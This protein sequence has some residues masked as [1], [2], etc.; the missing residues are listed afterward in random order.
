ML[1]SLMLC[2]TAGCF[3]D[4]QVLAPQQDTVVRAIHPVVSSIQAPPGSQIAIG[5]EVDPEAGLTLGS[6]LG[7]LTFD[8]SKLR[9]LGQADYDSLTFP[10]LVVNAARASSGELRMISVDPR[11][12]A[13]QPVVLAF[14]VRGSGYATQLRFTTEQAVSTGLTVAL[15]GVVANQARQDAAL[16]VPSRPAVLGAQAWDRLVGRPASRLLDSVPGRAHLQ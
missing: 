15:E 4:Q 16:V 1:L 11:G 3:S 10:L 13:A 7:T 8:P 9:Y 2:L 6:L 5:V 12:L 14:E